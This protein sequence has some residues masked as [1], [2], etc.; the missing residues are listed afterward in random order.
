MERIKC[1]IIGSD[2]SDVVVGTE[3]F[4]IGPTEGGYAVEIAGRFA[5]ADN[6]NKRKDETRTIHFTHSQVKIM[7]K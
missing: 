3:G 5:P 1:T 4:I 7:G 6:I 2:H